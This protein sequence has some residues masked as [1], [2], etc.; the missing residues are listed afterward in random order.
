M[1]ENS[2]PD[3]AHWVTDKGDKFKAGR[4]K[5]TGT[6]VINVTFPSAVC[7]AGFCFLSGIVLWEL[8]H[9]QEEAD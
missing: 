2:V 3:P 8:T 6:R 1:P 4:S 7:A 5:G 9:V